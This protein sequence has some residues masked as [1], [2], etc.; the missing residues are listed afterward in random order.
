MFRFIASA[1]IVSTLCTS[2]Y[3]DGLERPATSLSQA[4]VDLTVPGDGRVPLR[5][6]V[7]ESRHVM[8]RNNSTAT[9]LRYVCTTPCRLYVRPGAVDVTLVGWGSHEYHWDVPMHGGS[10]HLQARRMPAEIAAATHRD[11]ATVRAGL[12]LGLSSL[13]AV[14]VGLVSSIAMIDSLEADGA[15]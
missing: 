5:I 7:T 6:D 4:S 15:I 12:A 10:I 2:A 11:Q 3:A 8:V 13:G 14:S 1:L 9:G